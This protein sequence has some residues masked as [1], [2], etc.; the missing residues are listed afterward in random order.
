MKPEQ[1]KTAIK[2]WAAD[3]RPREK[4][5]THGAATLSDSELIG[6]IFGNGTREKSAV[7]LAREL[8]ALA[9][10]NLDILAKFS[11]QEMQQISG[12]GPAKAIALAACMELGKR[13]SKAGFIAAEQ[14]ITSSDQAAKIFMPDMIDLD[15]EIFAVLFLSRRNA[16]IHKE[17]ISRGGAH[18]TVVDV[19]ILIKKAMDHRASNII[20]SH[21]HPSKSLQA[22]NEDKKLTQQVKQAAELF[23]IKLLDHIII[24][25][26]QYFSFADEGIL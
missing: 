22:S 3:E 20:L 15:H 26:S 10:N 21:N 4:L 18:A 23:N 11:L 25:G 9:Q 24:A 7:D 19:R 12:I 8:L 14:V 13:R 16:V 6:I 1:N 17:I 2:N 5:L